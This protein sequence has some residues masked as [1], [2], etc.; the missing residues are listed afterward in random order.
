MPAPSFPG[1]TDLGAYAGTYDLA[2]THVEIAPVGKRL[3]VTGPN[4]P[5]Y[6][7]VPLARDEFW[8][9]EIQ[10]LLGFEADGATMRLALLL[11]SGQR[12]LAVRQ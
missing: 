12:I 11:P 7:L 5:R 6:R 4:E 1:A 3:Y 2:G 9:E 8:L 10:G